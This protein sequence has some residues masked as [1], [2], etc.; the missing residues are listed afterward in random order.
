MGWQVE[1][2]SEAR[3]AARHD[4]RVAKAAGASV[5]TISA[6]LNNSDYVS[7]EM[8]S[9]IQGTNQGGS[10]QRLEDSVFRKPIPS[11]SLFPICR[12]TLY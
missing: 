7:A 9:R 8:R 4:S 11:R 10:P 5:A 2:K 1:V 3:E 12:I 6:A